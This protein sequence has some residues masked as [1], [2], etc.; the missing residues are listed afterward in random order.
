M[1]IRDR[2]SICINLKTNEGKQLVYDLAKKSDVFVQNFSPPAVKS[3]HVDY[4]EI[5]KHNPQIVYANI[6]AFGDK[7]PYADKPG[8]DLVAQAMSGLMHV[9][10]AVEGEPT[11]MGVA[12]SDMIT[13]LTTTNGIL[14]ALY[15]RNLTGKGQKISTSLF[16]SSIASLINLG[17]LHLNAG[18]NPSRQGNHHADIMPYGVYPVK[19]GRY[20][21]IA[22]GN[23][24]H[25]ESL[26]H[27][28]GIAELTKDER[29]RTNQLRITNRKVLVEILCER[30]KEFETTELV[31]LLE[32]HRV[33]T[34]VINT[35]EEALNNEHV[36][37]LQSIEEMETSYGKIRLIK[38]PISFSNE[39][40]KSQSSP[41]PVLNEHRDLILKEILGYES[42]RIET[43]KK[44]KAIF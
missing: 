1:C 15:Y 39:D 5:S 13:G 9:T 32:K 23:D 43:L 22:S 29:F 6:S 27:A 2:K 30:L 33:P 37:Y 20:V 3:L 26:C 7:G 16:E 40:E 17:S 36:R 12:I 10:G 28:I 41:P 42:E 18:L 4:E 44:S 35:I 21:V 11:K 38:S 25:F 34:C 31:E 8:F 19:N 14:A 24:K